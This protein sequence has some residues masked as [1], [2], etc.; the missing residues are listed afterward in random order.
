MFGLEIIGSVLELDA[1]RWRRPARLD[2]S[3]GPARIAEF[4]DKLG[5]DAVDWTKMLA[6]QA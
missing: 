1:N 6:N 4:R 2:V 3:T 5:F